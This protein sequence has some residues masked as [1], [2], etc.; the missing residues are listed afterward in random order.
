VLRTGVMGCLLVVHWWF[1]RDGWWGMENDFC[2]RR[3]MLS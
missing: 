1:A 2:E 3:E